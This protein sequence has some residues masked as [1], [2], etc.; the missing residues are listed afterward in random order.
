MKDIYFLANEF[1]GRVQF[2]RLSLHNEAYLKQFDVDLSKYM[3]HS[4]YCIWFHHTLHKL[5]CMV[6]S[7]LIYF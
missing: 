1:K 4:L 3:K 2:I 6:V 5:L 7:C